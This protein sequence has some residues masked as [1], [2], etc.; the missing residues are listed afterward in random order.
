MLDA[1]FVDENVIKSKE[2][3]KKKWHGATVAD[4]HLSTPIT[5][6][7]NDT[8]EKAI[9]IM[10]RRGFDQLPVVNGSKKYV[11]ILISRL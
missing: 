2:E 1:G 3:E 9:D 7:P 10:R 4:L 5:I 6:S 8:L 11:L